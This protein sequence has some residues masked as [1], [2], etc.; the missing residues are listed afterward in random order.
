MNLFA[1]SFFGRRMQQIQ[2]EAVDASR[3]YTQSQA[4][5]SDTRAE[6]YRA[7]MVVRDALL[8]P[9]PDRPVTSRTSRR[10]TARRTTCWRS[11]YPCLAC[12]RNLMQKLNLHNTAEIVLYAVRKGLIR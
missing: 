9:Q 8:D 5:L 12:R 10:R 7:S 11:T 2:Q 3:R 4:L 6:V 1:G